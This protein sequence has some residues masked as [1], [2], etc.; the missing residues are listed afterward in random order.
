MEETN[1]N[2]QTNTSRRNFLKFLG[3]ASVSAV[4]VNAAQS[5][6]SKQPQYKMASIIDLGLCDGCRDREIPACVEACK[7][8]NTTNFPEPIA[9]IPYYFPRKVY[10]DYSK[11]RANTKRLTPYNW[12]YVESLKVEDRDIYVPRRCMHCDDPTCQKL[13]PFG[14]ISKDSNGAVKIDD[15]YCFGG[16]KCRDVCPWGIPQR[17]AG[18]G[19]YLK[20]APKL[21]GGGAM[22]KC[23]SCADLLAKNQ[24]PA[25]EVQCPKKAIIFGDREEILT[26]AKALQKAYKGDKEGTYIYGDTQ[27][28]GTSTFYV[29]P[30]SFE[31][32]QE[33]LNQKHNF[34]QEQPQKMGI[35]H[36]NLAIKNFVSEDSA[37]IKSVLLAPVAGVIAGGI[38]VAMANRTDKKERK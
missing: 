6:D 12:T 27:N 19:I 23:D 36:M 34:T 9:E 31:Q 22:Y 28:G 15:E 18:V 29:S 38:A 32:I 26:K 35:P 25:C 16:A 3:V 20:I 24:K 4:S 1:Q 33:S 7:A 10:E 21:A 13:C 8:K 2:N 30:V 5:T 11:D 14:V 17:Q 37:L